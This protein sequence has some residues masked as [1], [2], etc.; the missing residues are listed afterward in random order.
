MAFWGRY[1]M[2]EKCDSK[3]TNFERTLICNEKSMILNEE[4]NLSV[5]NEKDK[6]KIFFFERVPKRPLGEFLDIHKVNR[7]D[8]AQ[9]CG[10]PYSLAWCLKMMFKA[11]RL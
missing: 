8:A 5:R 7:K 9:P 6:N 3:Q 2:N 11:M 10:Q 4:N 1:S